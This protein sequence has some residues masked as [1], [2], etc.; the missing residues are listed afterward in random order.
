MITFCSLTCSFAVSIASR[1]TD[2]RRTA[3]QGSNLAAVQEEGEIDPW[4]NL[5]GDTIPTG[6]G[7]NVIRKVKIRYQLAIVAAKIADRLES[8]AVDEV[9]R[10][11]EAGPV[12]TRDDLSKLGLKVIWTLAERLAPKTLLDSVQWNPACGDQ[13]EDLVELCLRQF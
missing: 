13:K 6:I 1:S 10:H 8:D 11:H 9:R 7:V 3:P 4:H 12:A 5:P 2:E